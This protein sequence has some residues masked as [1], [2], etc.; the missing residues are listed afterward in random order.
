MCPNYTEIGGS[1][2]IYSKIAFLK[3]TLEHNSSHQFLHLQNGN[4]TYPTYLTR[5]LWHLW[6]N[7]R[8][9]KN[10]SEKKERSGLTF[11]RLGSSH[12][13]LGKLLSFM[14]L[15]F[16]TFNI[17]IMVSHYLRHMVVVYPSFPLSILIFAFVKPEKVWL[18]I[19]QLLFKSRFYSMPE[20]PKSCLLLYGSNFSEGKFFEGRDYAFLLKGYIPTSARI[21]TVLY[22]IKRQYVLIKLILMHLHCI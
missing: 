9:E 10:V 11:R 5:V 22:K 12:V 14:V 7:H 20:G 13:T 1:I 15:I 21:Y 8:T 3:S 17:Y 2:H 19:T 18:L 16:L 6:K 4:I